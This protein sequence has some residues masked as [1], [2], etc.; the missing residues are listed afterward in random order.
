MATVLPNI[1]A[2]D[3]D[4]TF[5]IKQETTYAVEVKPAAGNYVRIFA[6]GIPQQNRGFIENPEAINS[7]SKTTRIPGRLDPGQLQVRC[8]IKPRG[9]LGTE[10]ECTD[11]LLA[12]FGRKTVTGS[13]SVEYFLDLANGVL[14]FFTI[15]IKKGHTVYRALGSIVSEARWPLKADN[16]QDALC[17]IQATFL[18]ARMLKTGTDEAAETIGGTPQA[19]L[20]VK[21]ASKF[22]V[23]G[24]LVVGGDDN[25]GAGYEISSIDYDAN[26]LTLGTSIANVTTDDLIEPWIPTGSAVGTPVHGYCI[27]QS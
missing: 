2:L 25:S 15:W 17:Q 13:T 24:Y 11:V 8:L 19:T 22:D 3:Q 12:A 1:I 20:E 4:T 7:L 6:G 10:P 14:P 21:D 26:E 9:S 18:F 27:F 16:S 23:G 5:F